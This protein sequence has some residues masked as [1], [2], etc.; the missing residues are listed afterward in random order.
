MFFSLSLSNQLDACVRSCWRAITDRPT[1]A[2][3]K[4]QMEKKKKKKKTGDDD[5]NDDDDMNEGGKKSRP[6]LHT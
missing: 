2:A 6:Q 1:D 4:Q 5:E 3:S